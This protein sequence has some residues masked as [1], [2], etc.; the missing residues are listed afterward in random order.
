MTV[1]YAVHKWPDGVESFTSFSEHDLAVEHATNIADTN[2]SSE[3][4]FYIM[5]DDD[6]AMG[7]ANENI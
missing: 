4:E 1:H 2:F 7:K 5:C 6:H 3:H